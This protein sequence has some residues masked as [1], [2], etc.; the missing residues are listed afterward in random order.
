MPSPVRNGEKAAS[1]PQEERKKKAVVGL[2]TAFFV[3]GTEDVE[4]WERCTFFSEKESTKENRMP[5]TYGFGMICEGSHPFSVEGGDK[6]F[7][8][9]GA[10]LDEGVLDA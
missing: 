7:R 5:K 3:W 4:R 6:A 9:G 8:G 10:V 1:A 2:A